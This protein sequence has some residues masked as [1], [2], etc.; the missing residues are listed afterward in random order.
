MVEVAE[1][2]ALKSLLQEKE[3]A[4]SSLQLEL[5]NARFPLFS[6]LSF[7]SK[8]R[9]GCASWLN[10]GFNYQFIC[11]RNEC[12]HLKADLEEKIKAVELLIS[13]IQELKRQLEIVTVK[14]K[15]AEAENKMLVDRWMLQKMQDA[16]RL[17]EVKYPSSDWNWHLA[18][19]R[20]I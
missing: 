7:D 13:E 1:S 4:M 17:N 15:N 3:A 6:V 18:F 20:K 14:A 12:S 10:V 11:C 9:S 16:E 19:F 8:N 2:R 5:T